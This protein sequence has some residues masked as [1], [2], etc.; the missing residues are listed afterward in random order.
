[1]PI[2]IPAPELQIDFFFALAQIRRFYLSDAL[3]NTIDELDIAE[4]D[5]ELANMVPRESLSALARQGLRGELVFPV[6]CILRKNPRLL[7]YYRLFLGFSKKDFYKTAFGTTK[8]KTMEEKS[9]LSR[10]TSNYIE[11]L[12]QAL[13]ASGCSLL[14]GI[15]FEH[16]NRGLLNDL[17]LL[18]VGPQLRGGANVRKGL[19]AIERVFDLIHEIVVNHVLTT[20]IGRI[21]IRN[22]AGRNVLIEFAPDPDIVIRED[23]G[24]NNYRELIAV[25]IKGGTDFSNIHNRIGEAEKSHQKA[26][27]KGYNECWTVVN[28]DHMDVNMARRESPSTSRFYLLSQLILHKGQE[29]FDFR[30]RIISLTGI[31]N[32]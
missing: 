1:M 4:I 28:V 23:M 8:F 25:E 2:N 20:D 22:S 9:R 6:P 13:I 18:T 10:N 15:G 17:M 11:E 26:R 21:E 27:R 32:G 14:H 12:C 7:G 19:A 3:R 5:R 24:K 31:P 16:L 30:N 29:Y